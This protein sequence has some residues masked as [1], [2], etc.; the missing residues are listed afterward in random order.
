MSPQQKQSEHAVV[1]SVGVDR[2]GGIRRSPQ[3]KRCAQA[4]ALFSSVSNFVYHNVSRPAH[5]PR[6]RR[7]E[8]SGNPQVSAT[9]LPVR[10]AHGAGAAFVIPFLHRVSSIVPWSARS[11]RFARPRFNRLLAGPAATRWTILT[12]VGRMSYAKLQPSELANDNFNSERV[13]RAFSRLLSC[14][15]RAR[16]DDR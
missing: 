14:V 6:C 8:W 7:V 10:Q 12:P 3:E 5:K 1:D 16:A 4:G 11:M 9:S 2:H 13:G 15:R